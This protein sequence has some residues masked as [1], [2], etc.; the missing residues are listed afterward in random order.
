MAV[1]LRVQPD[2]ENDLREAFD[3]YESREA[4]LGRDFVEQVDRTLCIIRQMP[5]S[6]ATVFRS[7]RVAKLKR[8]PYIVCYKF[9]GRCIE[10]H[11]V[12]HAHRKPSSWQDRIE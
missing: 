3:W 5:E 2:A 11:A 9:D 12:F 10:V 8:F 6:Y 1:S 7:I 4:G